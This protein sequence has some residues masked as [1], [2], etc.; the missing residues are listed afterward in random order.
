M[1]DF[2]R[3]ARPVEQRRLQRWQV[4]ESLHDVMFVEAADGWELGISCYRADEV[5]ST[6]RFPVL[7][8]HG[9]GANRLTFDIDPHY[10]LARWLVEQGFDVYAV[11]LRGHGLS[12]KPGQHPARRWGWG[13]NAYCELDIPAAINAVLARSGANQ[14]HFIGH[15]MGGI[16]LYCHGALDGRH[17]RSGITMGSS[18]DY[19]NSTSFFHHIAPLAPLSRALPSVPLHWPALF[20]SW[21]SRFHR[22]FI[23]PVLVGRDNVDLDVYRKMAANVM[24]AVSA[25]V[26]RDMAAAITGEGLRTSWNERYQDRLQEKGYPFPVLAMSGTADI[27]CPPDVSARFGTAHQVFGKAHGHR[28]DYGHDDLI[29]GRHA[30]SEVWPVVHDWLRQHDAD[31]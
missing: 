21:A 12:E 13:F 17:V 23:D 4:E 16:L 9:L 31:A 29:M 18:L 30:P 14:L 10:S 8:C 3:H 20:S 22:G 2:Y 26:L 5:A 15:S 25:R 1:T 11:D 28:E 7:L 6:R 19:S 27:Q 24:H